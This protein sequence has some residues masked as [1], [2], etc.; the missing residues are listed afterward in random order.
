MNSHTEC[1]PAPGHRHALLEQGDPDE[2]APDHQVGEADH[3]DGPRRAQHVGQ[4]LLLLALADVDL[5]GAR[6]A[7]EEEGEGDDDDALA[8]GVGEQVPPH[9][10]AVG[11][12]V[13]VLHEEEPGGGIAAHQVEA[14]VQKR[15]E[16]PGEEVGYGTE[17]H[18]HQPACRGD[19]Q[20]V[21]PG[22]VPL[23][24]AG[25]SP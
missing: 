9:V 21:E 24:L 4:E 25:S 16:M 14:G 10:E 12:V 19:Y 17:D 15:L 23:A 2:E 20:A 11:D 5:E 6:R 22:E 8:A 1:R 18:G 3:P 7:R 13:Q